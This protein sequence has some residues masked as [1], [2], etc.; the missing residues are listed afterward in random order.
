MALLL[1]VTLVADGQSRFLSVAESS[2]QGVSAKPEGDDNE[3]RLNGDDEVQECDGSF[4]CWWCVVMFAGRR[5]FPFILLYQRCLHLT[6]GG[7]RLRDRQRLNEPFAVDLDPVSTFEKDFPTLGPQLDFHR[8]IW[9]HNF[10]E[11][12]RV[13]FGT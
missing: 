1:N 4:H 8:V 13:A 3:E 2:P 9:L 6:G 12:N 10:R 5:C 11:F 7:S